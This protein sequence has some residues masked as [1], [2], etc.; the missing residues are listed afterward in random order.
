M[1]KEGLVN[2]T[3][4]GQIEGKKDKRKQHI[5]YLVDLDDKIYREIQRMGNCGEL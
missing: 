1:R 4:T 3:H 2:L 5:T